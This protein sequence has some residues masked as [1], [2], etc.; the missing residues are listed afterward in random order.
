MQ[1]GDAMKKAYALL[2]GL[3]AFLLAQPA[4]A[5]V[6]YTGTLANST[7]TFD[8]IL[9]LS[10]TSTVTLQTYGFG[11]GVNQAGNTILPGGT[12][13]FVAIF[14]GVG[15]SATIVTDGL[16]NPFGTSADVTN[17]SSFVG[18]PLANT[19]SN[20]GSTTCAD[21]KMTLPSLSAGTYTIVLSDGQYQANAIFDNGTLG[22]GFTDFTTGSFCNF[23][24]IITSSGV[25]TPC[26]N[27]SGAFA[28][29]ITGLP[30]GSTT[31]VT[32]EPTTLVLLGSG[33]LAAGCGGRRRASRTVGLKKEV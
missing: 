21:V 13:P 8:V 17:Y 2:F 7:T 32:P 1:K 10:A 33:L 27:T 15:D 12:D 6:S 14:S 24:D 19:V 26:P 29:D 3:L 30:P 22:E 4:R 31:T 5:D 16:A 23:E 25:V 20:F 11:G 18:C 9:N 28:L